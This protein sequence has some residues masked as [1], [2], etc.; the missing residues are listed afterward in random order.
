MPRSRTP[1]N[2]SINSVPDVKILPNI[3][4]GHHLSFA[5]ARVLREAVQPG[6]LSGNVIPRP[7]EELA[8]DHC[9]ER[10]LGGHGQAPFDAVY[11]ERQRRTEG[12]LQAFPY[13]VSQM[14]WDDHCGRCATTGRLSPRDVA[15]TARLMHKPCCDAG[16]PAEPSSFIRT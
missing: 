2:R 11:P 13:S 16:L 1:D 4:G 12:K 14:Y 5:G 7:A 6:V 3:D 10:R 15:P 8:I 9:R